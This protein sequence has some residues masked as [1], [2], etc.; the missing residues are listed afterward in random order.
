MSIGKEEI[1]NIHSMKYLGLYLDGKWTFSD[2]INYIEK[3]TPNIARALRQIMLNMRPGENKRKLYAYTI[4][5]IINYGV[6]IWSDAMTNRK[7]QAK[8]PGIRKKKT[9]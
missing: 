6:P 2:H 1:Q 3:K 7:L 5:L 4:N 8:W 9:S